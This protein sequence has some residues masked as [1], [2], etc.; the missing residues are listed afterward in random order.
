MMIL[1]HVSMRLNIHRFSD[2]EHELKGLAQAQGS[3]IDRCLEL[4][5]INEETMDMMRVRFDVIC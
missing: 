2:V 1:G 4:V 5:R 3:S